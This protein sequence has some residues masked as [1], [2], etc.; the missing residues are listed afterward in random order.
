M[1]YMNRMCALLKS[2]ETKA[3]VAILY[4]AESD[5]MGRCM[6]LEEIA[7][8]LARSQ[9]SYDFLPAD[10]FAERKRYLTDLESGLSVNGKSYKALILPACDFLPP[11]VEKVLPAL[12]EKGLCVIDAGAIAP[13][14]IPQKLRALGLRDANV[15]PACGDI[16]ALHG[17]G[18]QEYWIF[19]NEGSQPWQ[20]VLDVPSNGPC[21]QYDA[22]MNGWRAIQAE[23]RENGTRLQV[24]LLPLH[25]MVV[26]F[27]NPPDGLPLLPETFEGEKTRL[28][29]GW[30][31][32]ICKAIDY[33]QFAEANDVCL[34][35]D[36]A[37]EKPEFSGFACRVSTPK[38]VILAVTKKGVPIRPLSR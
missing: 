23:S 5:W 19:V 26:I 30:K 32:S 14:F 17:A 22:W 2:G 31:R 16:R 6:P 21:Y 8:P 24:S 29:Q 1:A 15:L 33:P 13:L 12:R 3:D 18:Q 11:C 25:S 37:E 38:V 20:G 36:L 7:E 28:N 34:P 9:I 10:V 4:N 35:D 27:G